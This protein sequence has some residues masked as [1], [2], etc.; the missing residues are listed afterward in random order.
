MTLRWPLIGSLVALVAGA[1]LAALVLA[2]CGGN[3]GE[4]SIVGSPTRTPLSRTA[5]VTRT[6]KG[7]TP[8]T[9]GTPGGTPSALTP[10]AETATPSGGEPPEETPEVT[11]PPAGGDRD[12]GAGAHAGPG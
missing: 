2:F 7:G 6:P 1:G 9:T 5:T 3:E 12:A 10:P 8:A 11:P 4:P